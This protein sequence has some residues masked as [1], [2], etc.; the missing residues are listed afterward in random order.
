MKG[1]VEEVIN[2]THSFLLKYSRRNRTRVVSEWVVGLLVMSPG[3]HI[4]CNLQSNG[5]GGGSVRVL[6]VNVIRYGFP[7]GTPQQEFLSAI[8]VNFN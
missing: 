3:L 5:G 2:Y 7:G 8:K 1:G 4:A 6:H